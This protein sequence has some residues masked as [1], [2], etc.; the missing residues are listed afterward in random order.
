MHVRKMIYF[1]GTLSQSKVTFRLQHDA[2][3]AAGL[4]DETDPE[5]VEQVLDMYY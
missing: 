2:V 4:E 5:G 3:K 1:S